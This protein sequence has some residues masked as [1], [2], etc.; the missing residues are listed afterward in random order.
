MKKTILALVLAVLMAFGGT[1]SL[2]DTA[3]SKDDA[4]AKDKFVDISG[5]WAEEAINAVVSE[6]VFNS[7]G[8]KFEPDRLITRSEFALLLHKALGIRILY[9][10]APDITEIFDDVKNE[11]VFASALNDLV[12]AGVVDYKGRFGPDETLP[13]DDMVHFIVNSLQYMTGGNYAMIEIYP[14]PFADSAD[15][16]PAYKEDF[17]KAQV[18][19]LVSGTDGGRFLPKNGATRAEAAIIVHRLLN[20]LESLK[21]DEQVRVVPSAQIGRDGLVFK[22]I[23]TNN[24]GK[25]VTIN[26]SSGQKFDFK[27]LDSDRNTLYTWSEDK[28]FTMALTSTVLEP[29]QTA[30]FSDTVPAQ[31][32][33]DK[34]AYLKAYIAGTSDDFVVDPEGYETVVN[35]E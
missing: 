23:I 34:A 25:S 28:M 5:H 21:A 22:L 33:M 35:R 9:F 19:R 29:G 16:N 1:A 4:A 32:F 11:D 31:A 10:K 17:V 3:A 8:G 18:L 27:L 30:E 14:N 13:R 6:G 26:H 2:A 7:G 24:T 20:L 15:I 12:T